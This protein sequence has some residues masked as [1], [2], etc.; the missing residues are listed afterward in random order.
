[1]A[2][3]LHDWGQA[4]RSFLSPGK[5]GARKETEEVGNATNWFLYR[6]EGCLANSPS[7]LKL[8]KANR[9]YKGKTVGL[10]RRS[11]EAEIENKLMNDIEPNP[12]PRTTLQRAARTRRRIKKRLEKGNQKRKRKEEQLANVELK[13]ATWNVRRANIY[14]SRFGEI[15]KECIEVR[16]ECE[17]RWT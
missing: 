12:G 10:N 5:L 17:S 13:V 1:M 11:R 15:V 4:G 2:S 7:S 14:N 6:K 16:V 9:Q 3:Y 8:S